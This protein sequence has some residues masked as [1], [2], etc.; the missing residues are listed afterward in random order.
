ML[1]LAASAFALAPHGSGHPCGTM[2]LREERLAGAGPAIEP[3]AHAGSTGV[4]TEH[5]HLEGNR[6]TATDEELQQLGDIFEEVWAQEIDTMGYEAPYGTGSAKFN[7]Y[8]ENMGDYLYGY[9]DVER[10]GKTPYIAIN[11]DM[12]WSGETTEDAWKVTAAHEFF[13]AVQFAY[14]YWEA[15]WWMEA[16]ATWM[17]DE[18]YDSIDDYDYYLGENSWPD[19]PEI[20]MTAEDGWHEYGE[21]IWPRYI[22]TFHGG[23]ASEKQLWEACADQDALDAMV[24]F[25][26][27]ETDFNDALVDFEVRNVLGYAGYE[28]GAD[29]WPM[30]TQ[31]LVTDSSKLPATA[32]PTEY[33]ADYLGVNYW[34][35]PVSGSDARTLHVDFTAGT[36]ADGT[37]LKWIVTVVGTDGTTWD[38]TTVTT[39]GDTSL[40]L[41][42]FGDTWNEGWVLVGILSE[43]TGVDHDQ[44]G[45]NPKYTKIPPAYSFTASLTDGGGDTGTVD[46]GGGDT[47]TVDTGAEDTGDT[48]VADDSGDTKSPRNRQDDTGEATPAGC[49]C[50]SGGGAS[51]AA[52]GLLLAAGMLGRRRR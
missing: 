42:G 27:S 18:V 35:I 32:A 48:A 14:D 19:Y 33:I 25:F 50:D 5:F 31:D 51:G 11:P 2:E 34:R 41:S 10:D 40:D 7:V 36:L 29:W 46:T 45:S 28:E 47:G 17:E 20:S 3:V 38:T 16:S 24:D 37:K 39:K 4:D 26:G 12:S 15:S 6:Y 52:A 44:Y 9:T 23:A 1:L 49:G 8:L 30:Y 22:T 43:N 13:H 21:V